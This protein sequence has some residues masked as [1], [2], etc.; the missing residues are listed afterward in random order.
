M[1]GVVHDVVCRSPSI[2]RFSS[3]SS[4]LPLPVPDL[5][6]TCAPISH[7]STAAALPGIHEVFS[8][9]SSGGL[10][11]GSGTGTGSGQKL[12]PFANF[13]PHHASH[14]S[15]SPSYSSLSSV[16]TALNGSTMTSS[17]SAA[18]AVVAGLPGA[19]QQHDL[20][21]AN[22]DVIAPLS[23]S[24]SQQQAGVVNPTPRPTAQLPPI[25]HALQQPTSSAGSVGSSGSG[26]SGSVGRTVKD[27]GVQHSQTVAGFPSLDDVLSYYV[28]QGRLFRCQHCSI[29]FFERGMYFLHASLHGLNS[30]W[31]CSICHK[32]CSDKN[33]FTL[34]FVNQQHNC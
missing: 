10:G 4:L 19:S 7:S 27:Q 11:T 9:R 29:L 14:S 8:R 24:T 33:E 3:N 1:T 2:G 17:S 6:L 26:W 32:V 31:E 21:V 25:T 5:P 34:H 12:P 16:S 22:H 28:G 20:T 13:I 15:S 18:A 23:C 30:P